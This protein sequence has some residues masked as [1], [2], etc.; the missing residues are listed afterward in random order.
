M[1]N[2]LFSSCKEI[3]NEF[4]SE[5]K[6]EGERKKKCNNNISRSITKTSSFVLQK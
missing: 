6:R 4:E 2:A 3:K 5:R 1:C